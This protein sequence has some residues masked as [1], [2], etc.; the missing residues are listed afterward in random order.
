M[1]PSPTNPRW[2][3]AFGIATAL[4]AVV[5]YLGRADTLAL[6]RGGAA[7]F[8]VTGRA[9]PTARAFVATFVAFG[10]GAALLARSVLN[11][12]PFTLGLGLGDYRFALKALAWGAPFALAAGY[13]GARAPAI[14]AVYPLGGALAPE[15]AAFALHAVLYLL[16]YLGFE[17]L[18]RGFLLLGT[19]DD[20]GP[21][22]ANLLQACLVT[23]FHF[24]KPGMEMAAAFPASLLFGW[25]TLRTGSIWCALAAHWIVG[26]SMDFFL[27]F[28]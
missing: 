3:W 10:V 1:N 28:R 24:G 25:A 18:F 26:V 4:A 2:A 20:I 6:Q 15:P 22:A 27:V 7:W 14:A 17:Y 5:W 23:A 11:R 16:Y 12:S 13:V 21:A 8:T 9:L 19:K